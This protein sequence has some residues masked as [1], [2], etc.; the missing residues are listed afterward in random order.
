VWGGG[1]GMLTDKQEKLKDKIRK[2]EWKIQNMKKEVDA[3]KKK[4]NTAGGLTSGQ[5]MQMGKNEQVRG[6]FQFG[7]LASL[8]VPTAC[9]VGDVID[10]ISILRLVVLCVQEHRTRERCRGRRELPH[11]PLVA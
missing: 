7:G 2:K 9:V 10:K 11:P 5:Q 3:I 8:T 6:K 4:E 1:S